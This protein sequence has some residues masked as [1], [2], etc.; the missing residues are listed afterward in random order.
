MHNFNNNKIKKIICLHFIG[1][2][3]ILFL[4]NCN[5][6]L[7]IVKA[8]INDKI[9][10]FEVAA[11]STARK[12]GLMYRKKLN[13]NSGMLFVYKQKYE[14]SFYMKNTIIPLDI[15]FLDENFNI[16]DI[17]EMKPLDNTSIKSKKLAQYALEVNRGFFKKVGLSIGDK[18]EFI[19]SIPYIE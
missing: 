1:I 18:I 7:P 3:T 5:S 6:K 13:K 12:T 2:I 9:Y 4:I 10:N 19:S 8:K 14:L 11:T 15:A 17:Q 16:V